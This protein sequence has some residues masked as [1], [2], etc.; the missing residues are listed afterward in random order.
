MLGCV[1]FHDV[2]QERQIMESNLHSRLK[3]LQSEKDDALHLLEV[4]HHKQMESQKR[5]WMKHET[6]WRQIHAN[7]QAHIDDLNRRIEGAVRNMEDEQL[8]ERISTV[9]HGLAKEEINDKI[10]LGLLHINDI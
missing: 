6:E 9:I 4:K 2:T 10:R 8:I 1:Q 7:S 5:K 3:E